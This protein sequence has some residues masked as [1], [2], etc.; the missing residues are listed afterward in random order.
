M[1]DASVD[2]R[3]ILNK[4]ARPRNTKPAGEADRCPG[5]RESRDA[6]GSIDSEL[7]GRNLF[8]PSTGSP[9]GH[10]DRLGAGRLAD[11]YAGGDAGGSQARGARRRH[12]SDPGAAGGR[13]RPQ[14]GPL[15]PLSIQAEDGAVAQPAPDCDLGLSRLGFTPKAARE[16]LKIH[17]RRRPSRVLGGPMG[18][19]I[20]M[21]SLVAPHS[22]VNE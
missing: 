5:E 15:E 9:G 13:G 10:L 4:G 2:A 19:A 6:M 20:I 18:G 17:D 11:E 14:A 8:P 3:A 12:S 16:N 1:S 22:A 7:A 21:G